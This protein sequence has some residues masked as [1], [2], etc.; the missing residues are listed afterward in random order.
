MSVKLPPGIEDDSSLRLRGE[1]DVGEAGAPAGD[2]YVTCHVLPHKYFTRDGTDL[3]CETSISMT[4]AA[5]GTTIQVPT[6]EGKLAD[7]N[8]PSGTQPGTILRLKGKGLPSMGSA[9]RGNQLVTLRVSVPTKLSEKQKD[10]LR[11]LK[12]FDEERKKGGFFR[13]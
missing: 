7:V 2:L 5:L 4:D 10:L 6:I 8:V 1:G 11:Q 3:L 9:S 13:F 12:Q